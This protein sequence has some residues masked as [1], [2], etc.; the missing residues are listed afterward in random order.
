M[1][2]YNVAGYLYLETNTSSIGFGSWLLQV[3]GGMSCGCDEN[4]TMGCCAILQ[5]QAKAYLM[6]TGAT[7]T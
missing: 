6:Q 2:F 1:K 4:H 3:R 7:A 5:F